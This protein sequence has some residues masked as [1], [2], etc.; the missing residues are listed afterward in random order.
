MGNRLS[1]FKTIGAYDPN[2]N[3]SID[4]KFGVY[5]PEYDSKD[6]LIKVK[7]INGDVVDAKGF[8]ITREFSIMDNFSDMAAAFIKRPLPPIKING[9]FKTTNQGIYKL[10]PITSTAKPFLES[11]KAAREKWDKERQASLTGSSS[12]TQSQQVVTEVAT[13]KRR[14]SAAAAR[15]KAVEALAAKRAKRSTS[16][17]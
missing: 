12:S 6:M 4:W 13:K 7:H 3:G 16:L 8:G 1:T 15:N 5:R 17:K 10:P 2:G 11:C 9:F 14:L